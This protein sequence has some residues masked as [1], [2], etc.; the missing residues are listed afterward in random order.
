MKSVLLTGRHGQVSSYLQ[1]LLREN[2]SLV[3][4]DRNELD[5]SKPA[6]IAAVLQTISPDFIINPAAYTGVDLAEEEAEL[7]YRINSEAPAEI[8][9]YCSESG[10]P[11]IHFSTDY[12][13]DGNADRP[14]IETDSAAPTGVY[15]DSKL[16]GELAVL[17]SGAP[18]VI[19]RTSWVYSNVGKNFYRTMLKLAESRNQLSVV[20]DQVGSPTYAGSIAVATEAILNA[21]TQTGPDEAQSGVFHLTCG[22]QTSW[23][24][25]AEAIFNQHGLN[26]VEV[27]PIG[28]ADYPTPARRPA[29]SVLNNS[30][31]DQVYGIALPDWQHALQQC[32]GENHAAEEA[33]K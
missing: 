1:P 9:Q 19:L 32:V 18:A 6:D 5:L 2:Y 16:K 15:G 26:S 10:T 31:L 8:A 30:K 7:A 29:Y 11:L 20:A 22:G 13:F 21:I 33:S 12:V 3:V 4:V 14:Y 23:H 28:T 24:G 17:E 27:S 25:F